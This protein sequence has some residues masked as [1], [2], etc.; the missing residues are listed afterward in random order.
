MM[1]VSGI[2]EGDPFFEVEQVSVKFGGLTALDNLTFGVY[3]GEVLGVIGPNGAGKSTLINVMTGIYRPTSGYVKFD[4]KDLSRLKPYQ[5]ARLGVRRTFQANRLCLEL[6]V[7]DNI[8]IGMHT[9]TRGGVFDAVLRRGRVMR[10]IKAATEIAAN[11]VAAMSEELYKRLNDPV[12]DLPHADKRRV[13]VARALAARP[14]LLLLDEPAAG[15]GTEE[16]EQFVDSIKK[17]QN[18]RGDFSI[19]IIEH[20]M[21]L[22]RRF[23][24]R[25]MVL[26]YGEQ[27]A[28]GNF[29]EVSEIDAVKD[30]YLGAGG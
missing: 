12:G 17:I 4:G 25:V 29:D 27:I 22:M 19:M 20:D 16:T 13:E 26:N 1:A 7:L 9:R 3:P 2:Q 11:L 30:A 15:M 14:R 8:L 24:D 5:I 6:S 21:D 23:P 28:I 10:D 18:D